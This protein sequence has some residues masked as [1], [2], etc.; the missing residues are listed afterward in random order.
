MTS[1]AF[2]ARRA[3]AW[4]QLATLTNRAAGLGPAEAREL[5]ALYRA[6]LADLGLLRT[7]SARERAASGSTVTA[8][9]P[10]L[11]SWLNAVVARAHAV[12]YVNRRASRVDLLG[13]FARE[14]PASIR[15]ASLRL[16]L[17]ALLLFGSGAAAYLMASD[18]VAL[19][20]LLAGP[21]MA[22]NAEGFAQ[23]GEGR[24]EAT[25]AVM[26][27]FYVTNNVRVAFVAF[28][29]GITFG[30]GT[31]WVL[32]QN[33]FVLGVT[34]ALVGHYGSLGGFVA[35]V[36]SH[37]PIELFAILLSSAAGLGMGHALV[38]PGP[39]TRAVAL[40][41]AAREAAVLVMGAACL[42]VLAAFLEAFLSPSALPPAA[43]HAVGLATVLAL[44]LYVRRAPRPQG[45]VPAG[46][47][48]P[49]G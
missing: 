19:A 32:A 18:D 16:A 42:L 4:Q 3:A 10:R 47:A 25:D 24:S 27:A 8:V 17:A 23:V 40:K 39:H 14:L 7:L 43:K 11:L 9:E 30:L 49:S 20:R 13:F 34:L 26:A 35:F 46:G 48:S 37:A 44:V 22:R 45:A 15:R 31:L 38:A 1:E 29:L 6:S 5:A 21:Q 36:S 2:A 41:L 28:A 12:V 33:G